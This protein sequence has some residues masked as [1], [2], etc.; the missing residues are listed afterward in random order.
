[1]SY[2]VT[3]TGTPYW[4]APEVI[5]GDKMSYGRK[6]DIWSLGAVVIEMITGKPPFY[7]LAPMTALFKVGSTDV[8]PDIPEDLSGEGKDF[9]SRCFQR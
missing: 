3:V 4:R 5:K 1:M 8:L 2:V 9:L 7:D 6:A